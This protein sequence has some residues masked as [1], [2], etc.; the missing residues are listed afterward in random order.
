M[1]VL[2]LIVSLRPRGN[3][4]SLYGRYHNEIELKIINIMNICMDQWTCDKVS[5]RAVELGINVIL[6][7]MKEDKLLIYYY[8]STW[9][10]QG[11]AFDKLKIVV[12]FTP[13]YKTAGPEESCTRIL[14]GEASAH[15]HRMVSR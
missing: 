14:K 2:G 1:K 9:I 12:G 13:W 4:K 8:I 11:T 10:E 6:N 5:V 15:C 7:E 3:M